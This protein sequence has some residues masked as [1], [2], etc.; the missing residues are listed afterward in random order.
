MLIYRPAL[1]GLAL[2]TSFCLLGAD[3]ENAGTE[4]TVGWSIQGGQVELQQG[5]EPMVSG[6]FI[7]SSPQAA[8]DPLAAPL[9]GGGCLVADLV[10]FGIGRASCVTNADCN[11]PDSIDKQHDPRLANF[12]GYCATRDA[13]TEPPRCWTRPGLPDTHCKRSKDSFRLTAGVHKLGPVDA[14]PLGNGE[15]YPEWAVFA[16]MAQAGHDRACGEAGSPFRQ[17]SLTPLVSRRE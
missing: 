12:V 14:D 7:V 11:E 1:L 17:N 3:G 4:T 10:P 15:P 5:V 9:Q 2:I 8:T 6:M 16:C 13:S